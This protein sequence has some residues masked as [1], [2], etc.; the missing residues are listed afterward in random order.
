[1]KILFVC[2]GNICRSPLAE[3]IM[4]DKISKAG[5]SG[6]IYVDSAGFEPFHQGD[7]ADTRAIKVARDHGIDLS[8]HRARLFNYDDFKNFDLIYV[9]DRHNYRDVMNMAREDSDSQKV[10]YLLNAVNPGSN[11]AVPD[12]WYGNY[13]DFEHTYQLLD[14]ATEGLLKALTKS[15]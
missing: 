15:V 5:L 10:D 7:S 8:A 4:R 12:P 13:Q 9:M 6:S 2:L 3:G 1:M 14:K 11:A